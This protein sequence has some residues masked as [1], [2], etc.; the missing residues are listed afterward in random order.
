M[1]I[2]VKFKEGGRLGNQLFQYATLRNLSIIKGY[3]MYIDTNLEVQGQSC[4]LNYFNIH[5]TSK[6][7]KIEYKYNQPLF[8]KSDSTFVDHNLFKINDNTMI[9]GYF[10]NIE[11]FRENTETIQNELTIKD[12]KINMVVNNYINDMNKDGSKIIAIHF[13]R[14]DVVQQVADVNHFNEFTTKF[15]KESLETIMKSESNVKIIVFTGGQRKK[16]AMNF[17]IKNNH[18]DDIM[19]VKNFISEY[20]SKYNIYLSPG[21]SM[22]NELIDFGLLS[23]CDYLITPYQSTFSFMAYFVNKNIIKMFSPTDLFGLK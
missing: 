1:T 4:L 7:E 18:D 3:D 22:N 20:E 23:K 2:T 6:L 21:S 5:N 19:W 12:D 9:D 14:G 10:E 16:G 15:V 17:W 11:Y 8:I 13:R